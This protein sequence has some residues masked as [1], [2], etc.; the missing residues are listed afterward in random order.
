VTI[1]EWARQFTEV[2]QG[3]PEAKVKDATFWTLSPF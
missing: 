3:T 2:T 1:R